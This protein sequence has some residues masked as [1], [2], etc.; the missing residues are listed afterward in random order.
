ML[1]R[2]WIRLDSKCPGHMVKICL[3]KRSITEQKVH[4]PMEIGNAR[5]LLEGQTHLY[6]QNLLTATCQIEMADQDHKS[7]KSG[8]QI[9]FRKHK[10]GSYSSI[11][12]I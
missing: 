5:S 11:I 6:N 7:F 8:S 1:L 4:M 10:K 9:E 2:E 12:I 3:R